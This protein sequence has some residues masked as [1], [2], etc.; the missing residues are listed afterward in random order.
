VEEEVMAS[1]ASN[2]GWGKADTSSTPEESYNW[3]K[4]YLVI[5]P[6]AS[7]L[8][9][10][11]NELLAKANRLND[12]SKLTGREDLRDKAQELC[13]VAVNLQCQAMSMRTVADD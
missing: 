6:E 2:L 5:R 8:L 9:Q 13:T 12:E 1:D 10:A 7:Q 11:A 4:R 3:L